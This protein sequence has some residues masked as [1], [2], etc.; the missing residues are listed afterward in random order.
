MAK[1]KIK[2]CRN[3]SAKPLAKLNESAATEGK[4]Y[5]FSGVFTAC[6]TD[7]KKIINRNSRVYMESAVLPHLGYLRDTIKQNGC[8]LGELDHPEGRFDI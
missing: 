1:N 3:Y 6:S 4:K 2:I 5:V 7:K 8:L